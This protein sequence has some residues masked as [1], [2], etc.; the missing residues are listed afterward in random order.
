MDTWRSDLSYL[1][2]LDQLLFVIDRSTSIHLAGKGLDF[3]ETLRSKM[4][5]L[6]HDLSN[7]NSIKVIPI[8]Y[9]WYTVLSEERNDDVVHVIKVCNDKVAYCIAYL[10]RTA[11]KELQKDS[12]REASLES[13]VI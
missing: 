12:I 7:L 9:T 6:P 11:A 4:C 1:F 3:S 10:D 13:C 2:V 8:L 5:L